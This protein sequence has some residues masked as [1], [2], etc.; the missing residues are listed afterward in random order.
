MEETTRRSQGHTWRL[1]GPTEGKAGRRGEG[2]SSRGAGGPRMSPGHGWQLPARDGHG[3]Y[4]GACATLQTPGFL[5]G[6]KQ[7]QDGGGPAVS[8]TSGRKAPR[9]SLLCSA[10]PWL[11]AQPVTSLLPRGHGGPAERPPPP[12]FHGRAGTRG[13]LTPC[14]GQERPPREHT[15]RP[16]V[17]GPARGPG[18]LKTQGKRQLTLA[19]GRRPFQRGR[20]CGLG[21]G[22]GGGRGGART[23]TRTPSLLS[24]PG[25]RSVGRFLPRAGACSPGCCGDARVAT[26]PGSV[27]RG[28]TFPKRPVGSKGLESSKF[29]FSRCLLSQ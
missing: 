18:S 6:D 13:A 20:A 21:R 22:R 24:G 5:R 10:Q 19:P 23:Q 12:C 9:P 8:G 16:G 3:G 27:G 15:R 28:H 7:D 1:P 11:Q 4:R 2:R 26:W 17:P 14:A 29:N 25:R